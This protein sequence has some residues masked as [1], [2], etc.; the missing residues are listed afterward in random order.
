MP[1]S[2]LLSSVL[3]GRRSQKII[4]HATLLHYSVGAV[5]FVSAMSGKGQAGRKNS[6][7]RKSPLLKA[8]WEVGLRTAC[9]V[10]YFAICGADCLLRVPNHQRTQVVVK[11]KTVPTTILVKSSASVAVMPCALLSSI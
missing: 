7:G 2:T 4:E 6:K 8:G 10:L 5:G 3:L 1:E 9:A 11:Y